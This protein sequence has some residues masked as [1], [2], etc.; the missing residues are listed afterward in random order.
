M[1]KVVLNIIGVL[2]VFGC[3]ESPQEQQ[4]SS[5]CSEGGGSY[6][7]G[8][9]TPTDEDSSGGGSNTASWTGTKQL[10]TTGDD[11]VSGIT[12]DSS[13]NIYL[14]GFTEGP[15]DGNTSAGGYDVFVTKYDNT[16]VKKWTRLVGSE[17]YDHPANIVSDLSNNLYIVGRT[18][19][20]FDGNTNNEGSDV[21]LVK[22]NSIGEKQWS[23]QLGSTKIFQVPN[24]Y[25][26]GVTVDQSGFVYITGYTYGVFHDKPNQVR[27]P[28]CFF[29]KYSS[30]GALI[31]VKHC[32]QYPSSTGDGNDIIIDGTGNLYVYVNRGNNLILLKH[33]SDGVLKWS[34]QLG[35]TSQEQGSRI[36]TDTSGNIFLTGFTQGSLGNSQAGG[37]LRGDIFTTKYD[38]S[39][40][41]LWVKQLGSFEDESGGDI[42]TDSQGNIYVVGDTEGGLAGNYNTNGNRGI[43]DIFVVKYQNDGT[44]EWIRQIGT[45]EIDSSTNITIDQFDNAYVV[46]QSNGDFDGKTNLGLN[47]VFIIKYD[48]NGNR[49]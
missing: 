14:T 6:S 15:I 11:Y 39:G 30:E 49:L 34:R 5:G 12:S 8:S 29:A 4:F 18:S 40:N 46:L 28:E 2:L 9:Y 24:D 37:R 33:D 7:E 17:V 38:S 16:G 43:K 3:G 23:R 47:D 22:Y 21:F 10:G 26:T 45:F 31:W 25:G 32:L 42:S 48:S 35:T 27:S 41:I 1:K 20:N 36:A 19:G 44:L 13:G